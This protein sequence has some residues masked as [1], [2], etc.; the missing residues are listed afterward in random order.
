MSDIVT[1]DRKQI[2]AEMATDICRGVHRLHTGKMCECREDT[3]AS[4][5]YRDLAKELLIEYE[6]EL[7]PLIAEAAR[8]QENEACA[9]I[10]FRICAETRHVTLGD[11]V[12]AAIRARSEDAP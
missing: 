9:N 6:D 10:G 2:A 11:K 1:D 4:Y 3:C 7:R 8:K 5:I 12:Y